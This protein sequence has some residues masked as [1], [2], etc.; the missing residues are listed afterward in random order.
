MSTV[1]LRTFL[2]AVA[3]I[4][5]NVAARG[6]E[7]AG[8][9]DGP[10]LAL[11]VSRQNT[12][13]GALVA[14]VDTLAQA[15]RNVASLAVGYRHQFAG[16]LVVGLEGSFGVTNG[17]L[18]H[19]DSANGLTIDYKNGS[20]YA[21]G[22]TLG[23]VLGETRQTLVFAYLSETKRSFDVTVRGPLGVGAQKDEQGLLRYGAGVER[24]FTENLSLRASLGSSRAR[25][26]DRRTNIDPKT[27]IDFSLG[28]VWQF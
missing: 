17:D 25:F 23:Y 21:L 5:A 26:G 4:F 28:V 24:R 8:S 2:P 22:G 19:V 15:S 9:F 13:A 14:N 27:Q 18:K 3:L 12:I 20:Q 1:R 7:N 11:E 16:G 10:Y 6:A